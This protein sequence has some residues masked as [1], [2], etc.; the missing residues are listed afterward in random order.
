M[1]SSLCVRRRLPDELNVLEL[2]VLIDGEVAQGEGVIENKGP[3][4]SGL[5]AT[6]WLDA[7]AAAG[8]L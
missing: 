1:L 4:T 8:S 7:A 3:L 6:T 2:R 5:W